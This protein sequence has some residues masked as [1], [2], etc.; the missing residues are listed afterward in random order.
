MNSATHIHLERR[1]SRAG[2][3]N[4][5]PVEARPVEVTNTSD[6]NKAAVRGTLWK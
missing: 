2:L 1:P 6:N 5:R 4:P 3:R